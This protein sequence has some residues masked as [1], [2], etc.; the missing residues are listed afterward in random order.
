MVFEA[1]FLPI[2]EMG[3]VIESPPWT[4]GEGGKGLSIVDDPLTPT[5]VI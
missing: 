1:Q 2:E 4:I 3:G 5:M